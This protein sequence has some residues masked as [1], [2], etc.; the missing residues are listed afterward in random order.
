MAGSGQ[1]AVSI[2][3]EVQRRQ[4]KSEEINVAIRVTQSQI[5]TVM[6]SASNL[7]GHNIF[8]KGQYAILV[9]NSDVSGGSSHHISRCLNLLFHH[10]KYLP[11][12]HSD[13]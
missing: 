12:I 5:F 8:F 6:F 10:N 4:E 11:A 2:S 7:N 1:L 13:I 9:Y 3:V